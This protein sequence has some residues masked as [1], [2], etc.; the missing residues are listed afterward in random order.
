MPARRRPL[1]DGTVISGAGGGRPG[2]SRSM[3]A[4][5]KW[6]RMASCAAC[7]DGGHVVAV[8]RASRMADRVDAVMDPVQA[9]VPEPAL[10]GVPIDPRGDQL[11][12][13]DATVLAR[14]EPCG[15]VEIAAHTAA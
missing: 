8:E 9:A 1:S 10:D 13:G 14:C 7:Q 4:A 12:P 6:L 2:S 15:F 11:R 3:Y 5:A